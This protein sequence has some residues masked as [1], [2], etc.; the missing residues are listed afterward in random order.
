MLE[1]TKGSFEC[2][3]F[4]DLQIEGD[5]IRKAHHMYPTNIIFLQNFKLI[6][7]HSLACDT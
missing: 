1:F 2:L 4:I 5:R 3:W 6:S 7:E